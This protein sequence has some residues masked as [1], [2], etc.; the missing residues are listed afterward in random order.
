MGLPSVPTC[1]G[2]IVHGSRTEGRQQGIPFG[3]RYQVMWKKE[4]RKERLTQTPLCAAESEKQKRED[5]AIGGGLGNAA[6]VAEA[7]EG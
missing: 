5:K 1:C 7:G 2:M 3:L 6:E 4:V